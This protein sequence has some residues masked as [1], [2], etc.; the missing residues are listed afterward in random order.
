MYSASET[1]WSFN[2][3]TVELTGESTRG[4]MVIEKRAGMLLN[5]NVDIVRS[6]DASK[7]QDILLS[8]LS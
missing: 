1:L 4:Q 7:V 3:A 2:Q 5:P 6:L 8:Y